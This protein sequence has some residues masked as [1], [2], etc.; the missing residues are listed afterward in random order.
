MRHAALHLWGCIA[1]EAAEIAAL[2]LPDGAK[3]VAEFLIEE[4]IKIT[5]HGHLNDVRRSG[6]GVVSFIERVQLLLHQVELFEKRVELVGLDPEILQH[7]LQLADFLGD[8]A[9][10]DRRNTLG[11]YG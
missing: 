3:K 2:D 5:A 7:L 10:V 1:D 6:Q 11:R 4:T 9:C 8:V